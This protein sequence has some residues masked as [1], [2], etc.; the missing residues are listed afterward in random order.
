MENPGNS[1]NT[2]NNNQEDITPQGFQK[3][4][5]SEKEGRV[6]RPIRTYE[7]D[8]ANLVKNQKVSTAKIVLA[9]Q[10]KRQNQQFKEVGDQTEKPKGKILKIVISIILFGLGV[11]ALFFV[12]QMDLV[13]QAIKNIVPNSENNENEII[14]K[15]NSVEILTSSKTNTE[16]RQIILEETKK[17]SNENLDQVIE[18]EILKPGLNPEGEPF[19]EKIT[20]NNFLNIINSNTSDRFKRSI[21]DEF[22]FAVYTDSK[23]T[24]FII[25]KTNDID[26]SF[27]EIFNWES[28]MYRDLLQVL[29]LEP[30]APDFI[31]VETP[32]TNSSTSSPE[33]E[34]KLVTNPNAKFEPEDFVDIV[35]SNKDS[36]A[37][38]D[39]SDQI[40][41]MYSFIDDKNILITSNIN[42]FQQVIKR[43]SAQKLLR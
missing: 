3:E 42:V 4:T 36:R 12:V 40:I 35:I 30:E 7:N 27:S 29:D 17:L 15:E 11:A 13:P 19:L 6:I 31:K 9:E 10:K 1:I 39:T 37:I 28:R 26:L 8:I 43:L 2:E 34:T 41:L 25:L 33:T 20:A 21:E 5:E 32:T 14:K 22:L 24:P 16:I 18:F 23:P 38:V